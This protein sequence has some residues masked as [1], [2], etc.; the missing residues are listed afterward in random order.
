MYRRDFT[1]LSGAL[2]DGYDVV[3]CA[4][5]GFCFADGL[6]TQTEL[7]AYYESQSKYE[8]DNRSGAPSEYDTRRLPF[9]VS[10]IS[11]W[12]PNRDARIVDIG[13]AN[14]ALLAELRK[15]GFKDVMGIDP[16]SA[17]AR[18]AKNLYGIEVEV[19]PI[20]GIPPDIGLFDLV[21]FGSVME[22]I[23]DLN[24]TIQR[25]KQL[26]KPHGQAYIEV[27][28]M[29]KCSSVND[30]P[31]Q[32]F[33][34]EHINFFGPVSL[35][36]LWH[37]H[38]FVTTGLRQTEIEHVPGLTIYEIKAMFGSGAGLR[39]QPIRTD[40]QTRPEIERYLALAKEKL[41][42]I[43][44]VIN[45]LADTRRPIVVWGVGTHTQGLLASTRLREANI[46]AFVDSNARYVGQSLAGVPIR[47]VDD[48]KTMALPI[49]ISS[50]QFQ[51]EIAN[52]VRDKL[53][54]PNPLITLYD[55]VGQQLSSMRLEGD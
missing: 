32:E 44:R 49:L 11:E 39:A 26:L 10:I 40:I 17:C 27:P 24:G 9:A 13:C 16:S 35:E 2:L 48:L 7:D 30:A 47:P 51:A 28:D 25:I 3:W 45:E 42:R 5:C 43:E 19:A 53:H 37:K 22:H 41:D 20:S 31:F 46:K 23:L 52:T 33:S 6:P 55:P 4:I 8:H 12:L 50:Q 34:V 36:N 14:G 38:G 21:I 54:L 29:T 15:N 18:T 1:K